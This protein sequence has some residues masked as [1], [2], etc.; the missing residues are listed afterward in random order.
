MRFSKIYDEYTIPPDPLKLEV[1]E[2]NQILI[3]SGSM[4]FNGTD[5]FATINIFID[6]EEKGSI[7]MFQNDGP[8][9][10][11][12]PTLFLPLTLK[13]GAETPVAYALSFKPQSGTKSDR[14]DQFAVH[15][16]QFTS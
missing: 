16:L 2:A 8:R 7:S 13:S 5:G 10:L 14:A 6:D 1:T 15:L 9:H 3:V 4:Y 11:A 12:F